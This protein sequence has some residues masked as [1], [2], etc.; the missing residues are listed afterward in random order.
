MR[1]AVQRGVEPLPLIGREQRVDVLAHREQVRVPRLRVGVLVCEA[2][3]TDRVADLR[4]LRVAEVQRT[5]GVHEAV[6]VMA[7]AAGVLTGGA[8]DGGSRRG[9]PGR[10]LRERRG[11]KDDGRRESGG[12][13]QTKR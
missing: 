12:G 5:Q 9:Q 3:L 8:G 11:R 10:G 1:P 6:V 4:T 13:E 2:R 7:A